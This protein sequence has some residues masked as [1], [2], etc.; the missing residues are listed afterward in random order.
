MNDIAFRSDKSIAI[1]FKR[2]LH[3]N[4]NSSVDTD[5]FCH[6]RYPTKQ[7]LAWIKDC[8]PNFIQSNAGI[9]LF[10]LFSVASPAG[11]L[12]ILNYMRRKATKL[13][14]SR[15]QLKANSFNYEDRAVYFDISYF[16]NSLAESYSL[17]YYDVILLSAV[18]TISYCLNYIIL[19]TLG[20]RLL[21]WY[22]L[23]HNP[24]ILV[25]SVGSFTGAIAAIATISFSVLIFGSS[26]PYA[27]PE[28]IMAFP[29]LVPGTL[30]YNL[31]YLNFIFSIISFIA[32][33]CGAVLLCGI[34]QRNLGPRL[35]G[36]WYASHW[37][38]FSVNLQTYS[39][40]TNHS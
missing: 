38:T 32:I 7:Y 22:L 17:E 27:S 9:I 29:T 34:T 11:R 3:Q 15:L 12:F 31:N 18:T 30:Q 28:T 10:I 19:T 6:N 23:R 4:F 40:Y 20:I 36:S 1:L 8:C 24:V 37:Y 2:K 5:N 13:W 39:I 35:I 26:L 25:F 16:Y 21:R 14:L 33:W